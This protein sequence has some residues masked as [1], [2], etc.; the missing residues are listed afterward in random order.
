MIVWSGKGRLT[1]KNIQTLQL[2]YGGAIR[3]H[4]G[5]LNEMTKAIWAIFRHCSSTDE[6]P[7]HEYCPPGGI[8]PQKN[9]CKYK[10]AVA[11]NKEP[12]PHSAP[13]IPPD[14]AVHVK[15]VFLRLADRKLLDRCPLGAT[16]NQNESFNSTIW[17]RCP[18][19]K[20]S[21]PTSVSIAVNLAVIIFNHGM[22]GLHPLM[23]SFGP[24]CIGYLTSR[25]KHRL[26]QSA[27]RNGDEA[28]K[29]RKTSRLQK[30][31]EEQEKVEEEGD[32][33]YFLAN[34]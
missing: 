7:H 12:P 17:L 34:F 4:A 32:F 19:E 26:N 13:L 2:Y 11:V 31:A 22:K 24:L 6:N 33:M 16:Q 3:F 25:D 9:W 30:V 10:N 1:K 23:G 18:K 29:K 5:N 21:C 15:P 27:K 28:K 14:L 8:D 20:F